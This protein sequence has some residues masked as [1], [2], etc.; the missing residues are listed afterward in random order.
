MLESLGK[1]FLNG[2]LDNLV[3][4]DVLN[5]EEEEK[6][7]YYNAKTKDKVQVVAD[8]MRTKQRMAG[9][10]LLKTFFNIDQISPNKK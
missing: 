3:E 4:Q 5:W 8:S 1:N 10:M 7:K 2:I 6:Q 9:E